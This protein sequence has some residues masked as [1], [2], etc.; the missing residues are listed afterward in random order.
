MYSSVNN[1]LEIAKAGDT[2]YLKNGV[3]HENIIICKKIFLIGEDRCILL[4]SAIGTTPCITIWSPA[5]GSEVI[6]LKIINGSIGIRSENTSCR[7]ENTVITKNMQAGIH[8][9]MWIGNVSN[10]CIIDNN[11][12]G[13]F[14]ESVQSKKAAISNNVLLN[15]GFAGIYCANRTFLEIKNNIIGNHHVGIFIDRQAYKSEI[16][17]NNIFGSSNPTNDNVAHFAMNTFIK[18]IFVFPG[19]PF[20]NYHLKDTTIFD[21]MEP[22]CGKIGLTK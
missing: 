11:I 8:A 5:S 15:N 3:Y 20:F 13:I 12:D 14:L 21:W 4:F 16:T 1:A 10:N 6:N 2:I 19:D 22:S 18:P 9:I 17:C 7:I